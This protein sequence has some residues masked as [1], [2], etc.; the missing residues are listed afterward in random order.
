MGLNPEVL[1]RILTP[2]EEQDKR[3]EA[4]AARRVAAGRRAHGSGS[5]SKSRRSGG[6]DQNTPSDAD[7]DESGPGDVDEEEEE[8]ELEFEFEDDEELVMSPDEDGG[9]GAGGGLES[10]RPRRIDRPDAFHVRLRRGSS[11]DATDGM[12]GATGGGP[13]RLGSPPPLI[14]PGSRGGSTSNHLAAPNPH[15]HLHAVPPSEVRALY[16]FS[17]TGDN[18]TPEI[19]LVLGTSPRSA[20]PMTAAGKSSGSSGGPNSGGA[21]DAVPELDG[22]DRQRRRDRRSSLKTP[23]NSGRLSPLPPVGVAAAAASPRRRQR[24]SDAT[25]STGNEAREHSDLESGDLLP[26]SAFSDDPD[27]DSDDEAEQATPKLSARQDGAMLIPSSPTLNRVKGAPSPI[28]AISPSVHQPGMESLVMASAGNGDLD[29]LEAGM[30]ELELEGSALEAADFAAAEQEDTIPTITTP[31]QTPPPTN[32]SREIVVSIPSD[33]A[34]FTLLCQ[35]LNQLSALHTSQQ[36]MFNTAVQRLCRLVSQSITPTSS[37]MN[38]FK[39]MPVPS[40]GKGKARADV[41]ND[42]PSP[43]SYSKSDLYAWR[44]IFTLWI[45]AQ[46]FESTAERDRGERSV[47]QAEKRLKAFATEV[48]KRGL[49][50][51]RTLRRTESREAWDEFLRLNVLL[52]DLKRF[53]LANI[54]AARKI[55]KKHDKRT[56]LTASIGFPQFV[57]NSLDAHMDRNGNITTWAFNNVSLPHVLLASLTETL[58]P[59]LPTLDDYMCLICMDIAFKPIRLDCSHLFCVRCLAKMQRSGKAWCPLCRAPNVLKADKSSLDITTMQ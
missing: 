47:E 8:E 11:H 57:R 26:S 25:S 41:L 55:L 18:P 52:L 46:I 35:A 2:A 59:I 9:D 17:G 39:R 38:A 28:W 24:S 22:D 23:T 42:I 3:D 48:V 30:A 27:R 49:G 29:S 40:V 53:Q 43:S 32:A 51:R 4:D 56:A 6:S 15:H 37:K 19:R 5:D 16:A 21:R 54:N 13:S 33:V 50:D 10:S 34:F 31:D 14:S 58:L 12:D 44:Q 1:H 36:A 45:E 20:S 7:T